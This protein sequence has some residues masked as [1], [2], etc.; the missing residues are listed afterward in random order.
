[1]HVTCFHCGQKGHYANLCEQRQ[2]QAAKGQGMFGGKPGFPGRRQQ[3]NEHD[4]D[5]LVESMQAQT[6]NRGL[7]NNPSMAMGDHYD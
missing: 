6:E 7:S 3:G 2:N 5:Y 4:L 1:M